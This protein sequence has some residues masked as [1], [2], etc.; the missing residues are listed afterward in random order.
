LKRFATRISATI[1][2]RN[3]RAHSFRT[4]FNSLEIVRK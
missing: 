3:G 1:L 2:F 4:F